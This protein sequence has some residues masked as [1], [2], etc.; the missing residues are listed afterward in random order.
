MPPGL[1]E[2][3]NYAVPKYFQNPSHVTCEEVIRTSISHATQIVGGM[4]KVYPL[5]MKILVKI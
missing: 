5:R 4:V 1:L 3:Q 2:T